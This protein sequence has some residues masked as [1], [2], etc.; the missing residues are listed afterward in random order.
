[1]RARAVSLWEERV[2]YWLMWLSSLAK[3]S[4]QLAGEG[5]LSFGARQRQARSVKSFT[6]PLASIDI[7]AKAL[8]VHND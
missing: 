6:S 1:M 4:T 2:S 3:G 7:S 5:Q 8:A